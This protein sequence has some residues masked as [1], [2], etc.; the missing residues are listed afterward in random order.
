MR[1]GTPGGGGLGSTCTPAIGSN[2]LSLHPTHLLPPRAPC[3]VDD[4]QVS[5]SHAGSTLTWNLVT[6][7]DVDDVDYEVRQFA[8]EIR[9]QVVT[10]AEGPERTR[11]RA[12]DSPSK[13]VSRVISNRR[14]G[15]PHVEKGSVKPP[16]A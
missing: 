9:S 16:G 11:A 4:Q 8:A 10:R 12:A 14:C 5:L 2:P 7:A 13:R 3:L 1:A 6:A 15:W